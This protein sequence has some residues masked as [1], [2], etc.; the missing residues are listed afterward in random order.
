MKKFVI[1]SILIISLVNIAIAV[2]RTLNY[3]GKLT[4]PGGVAINA[5]LDMTFRI[6]STETGG[7][8]LWSETHSGAF[9][10]EVIKGLFDVELGSITPINLDFSVD[11]WLEL[12]VDGELLTPREKLST[13][14]YAFRAAIADSVAGG[15]SGGSGNWTLSGTDIL[16]NNTGN[17]GIGTSSPVE[18]LHVM[19]TSRFAPSALPLWGTNPY[20]Q[21]KTDPLNSYAL[22]LSL[23]DGNTANPRITF[24]TGAGTATI[25]TQGNIGL[26]LD[27]SGTSTSSLGFKIRT[28]NG[29]GTMTDRLSIL[30]GA[31]TVNAA[32]TSVN[33]GIGTTSPTQPLDIAGNLRLR[34]YLYD[35]NNT[36]GTSGQVLTRGTSGVL[37]QDAPGGI[38]GTGTANYTARWT[39]ISTLGT[40]TLF[41]NGSNVGI[42]TT[43]PSY[44]LH[45][46]GSARV[47]SLNINGSW[48]LPTTAGSSG[49]FLSYNGTWATPSVSASPA[50]SDTYVQYNSSSAFGAESAFAWDY[51][52][53]RL[54]I[55]NPTYTNNALNVYGP[56]NRALRVLGSGSL[57]S[58]GRLN[59]GDGDYVYIDEPVDDYMTI[60]A[61]NGISIYTGAGTGY[62]TSGQVLTSDGTYASWQ[63]PSGSGS[64]NWTLS[65]SYLYPNSTTYDVGIG[66][67]TPGY[68]LHVQ[69]T[70]GASSAKIGYSSAY[71]DNR[72]FFG[73]GSYVYIGEMNSDDRLYMRGSTMSIDI[74]GNTGSSGQV[75]KSNGTT[76]YWASDETGSG[77]SSPAGSNGAVQFNNSGSF[78]GNASELYWDNS[79][80]RLGLGTTV[81]SSGK[82]SIIH[83]SYT[84]GIWISNPGHG[85]EISGMGVGFDAVRALGQRYGVYATGNTN[86]VYGQ[87][88]SS[89]YGFLGGNVSSYGN[90]GVRGNGQWASGFFM[91]GERGVYARGTEY[92][93]FGMGTSSTNYAYLGWDG[94]TSPYECGIY[95]QGNDYAGFFN[96]NTY[97][98]VGSYDWLTDYSASEPTLRP[99]SPDWGYVG[100]SSYNWFR[101]YSNAYYGENSSIILFDTYDD[102]ALLHA[103]EGDTLW[104]PLLGHHVMQIRQETFPKCITNYEDNDGELFISVQRTDGLLIG[105]VRQLDKE[106]KTR[107][108]RIVERTEILADAVGANFKGD[109]SQ[110]KIF[111]FGSSAVLSGSR[112]VPFSNDFAEQLNGEIPAITLTAHSPDAGLWIAEKSPHGFLVRSKNGN[113]VIDFDWSAFARVE[114]KTSGDLDDVFR[115]VKPDIRGSYPVHTP[116]MK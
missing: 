6:Y 86:G 85:I 15:G 95:A 16:N 54:N 31:P 61:V 47:N 57:G 34:G 106:A 36:T 25:E 51:T 103:I 101:M 80:S 74:G 99:T 92:G 60:Y 50:G 46:N 76:L 93:V 4:D 40:G 70:G 79:N 115:T 24:G 3:Q 94:L 48:N 84:S 10:V 63:D 112:W 96:G 78:G 64:G 22:Q 12:V 33:L 43:L 90:V 42:G 53:N 114:V 65:G 88:N 32:F 27:I 87:M 89:N 68:K 14:S 59:F 100:T 18:K 116:K 91:G 75:L 39:G 67:I 7:S 105:A 29:S 13:V 44:N 102:L 38:S 82:L 20:V 58:S 9:Q 66:T 111:D 1:V 41:D 26:N 81:T 98:D 107:D 28:D 55:N 37:W 69:N 108:H 110:I 21:I 71:T 104:D 77:G 56:D 109:Y 8:A 83:S 62:G 30:K 73:D 113:G 17:V 2:P 19:G 97:F 11:Y 52:N 45:V 5:D 35:Y 23:L 49:Q 72:L